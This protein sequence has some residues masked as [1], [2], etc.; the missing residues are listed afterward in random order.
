MYSKTCSCIR[1]WFDAKLLALR[2]YRTNL[3]LAGN[4]IMPRQGVAYCLLNSI[5][6][7]AFRRARFIEH[8]SNKLAHAF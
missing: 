5:A 1:R 3:D 6:V 2:Y 7:C 8:G 4:K